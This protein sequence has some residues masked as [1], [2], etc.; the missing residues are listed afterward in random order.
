ML[1]TIHIVPNKSRKFNKIRILQQAYLNILTEVIYYDF[2]N[3]GNDKALIV[4]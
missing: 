4:I 3:N 1:I 2:S